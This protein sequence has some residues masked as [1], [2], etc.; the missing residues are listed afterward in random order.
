M[1]YVQLEVGVGQSVRDPRLVDLSAQVKRAAQT[2]AHQLPPVIVHFPALVA[3]AQEIPITAAS[4]IWAKARRAGEAILAWHQGSL[5]EVNNKV[6]WVQS[7]GPSVQ[8]QEHLVQHT[9]IH[10]CQ[11]QTPL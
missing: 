10:Y 4:S 11:K 8:G 7:D 2:L 9:P 5:C 6:P 1:D 3:V